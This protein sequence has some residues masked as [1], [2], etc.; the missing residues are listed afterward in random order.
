MKTFIFGTAAAAAFLAA[1]AISSPAGAVERT[2]GTSFKQC[3]WE[4]PAQFGP[5]ALVRAPI[6]RCQGDQPSDRMGMGGPFCEPSNTRT[7]R[8]SEWYSPPQYG[9]RAPLRAPVRVPVDEC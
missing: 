9:P 3:W 7:G 2:G 6:R 5:R 4:T 8:R 1:G